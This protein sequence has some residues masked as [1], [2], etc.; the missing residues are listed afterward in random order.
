MKKKKPTKLNKLT[1]EA[2]I[3][4]GVKGTTIKLT[5]ELVNGKIELN[6]TK[7]LGYKVDYYEVFKSTKRYSGFGTKAYF[8][9]TTGG[10]D[11]WYKN[12]KELKK[13]ARYYY[14]VRGVREVNG[15]KVYT[16]DSNKAWRLVK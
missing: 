10:I 4:L 16:K 6:W 14:K 2:K 5:S 11:N 12:T 15:E 9:T 7:S 1:K 13:G 8:K 3:K